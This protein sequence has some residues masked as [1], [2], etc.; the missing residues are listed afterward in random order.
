MQA[1]SF[2]QHGHSRCARGSSWTTR[3]RGRLLGK[4]RRPGLL[5][6]R[7][8]PGDW[9][10]GR[11]GGARGGRVGGC[12]GQVEEQQLLRVEPF[13]ALAVQAAEQRRDAVLQLA[14]PGL[15]LLGGGQQLADH[16]LE[17]GRVVRQ[18]GQRGGHASSVVD[19]GQ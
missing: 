19:G 10:G 5:R 6:R 12:R 3:R 14:N 7:R 18:R 17:Q 9:L 11:G 8:G 15:L 16:L 4:G 1:R 2:W 13:G